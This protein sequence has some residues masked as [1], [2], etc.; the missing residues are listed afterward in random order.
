M[1]TFH[2][3]AE[4][5]ALA[6]RRDVSG[7]VL[8]GTLTLLGASGRQVHLLNGSAAAI[9]NAIDEGT[10]FDELV[11]TITERFA[12]DE[13]VVRADVV[14]ALP[15]FADLLDVDLGSSSMVEAPATGSKRI[16][17]CGRFSRRIGPFQAL[18]STVTVEAAARLAE[19]VV[20]DLFDDLEAV[21]AP[22]VRCSTTAAK[23]LASQ[24]TL[25]IDMVEDQLHPPRWVLYR[26]G[27]RVAEVLTV[28]AVRAAVL[29]EINAA[30]I[31][32]LVESVGWHAGAVELP[33]G[34]VVF[35]GHSNAGK[36]TLV[37]QLVARGHGYLTDEA[38]AVDVVS[39]QV[40]SFPKSVCVDPGG[41]SLFAELATPSQDSWPTWH[42]DPKR[43]GPGR[44]GTPGKPVA[45][46]FPTYERNAAVALEQLSRH[47]ALDALLENSFDFAKVGAAGASLMLAF[48]DVTPCYRLRHGGQP[49]HLE[50]LE[51]HFA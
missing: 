35:P 48:A 14:D 44:L 47:E 16:G 33:A 43:I 40:L 19:S 30:P 25:R 17:G 1:T 7:R 37:T 10:T 12:A 38:V 50:L 22:L 46:V 21:L 27:E 11:G 39:R 45:F 2:P 15:S 6:R 18:E 36:S 23:V 34:V 28:P 5:V 8:D 4:L 41:K 3:D 32:A 49:E 20:K 9:W 26:N 42:V 31:D 29:A 51:S 13:K 24:I